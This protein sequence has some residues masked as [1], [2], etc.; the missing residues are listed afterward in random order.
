[1][2]RVA[3]VAACIALLAL[4]LT[5]C[6]DGDGSGL[7]FKD[8][9]GSIDVEEG[10]KFSLEFSVNA[11]VG[12][13]W[14]PVVSPPGQAE[15]LKLEDTVVDYPDEEREGDSG[16]K[17]FV[18]RAERSGKQTLVFRRLFRG[19]EDQRRTVTVSVR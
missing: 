15:I 8:P 6:N 1:V 4:A 17:R 19:D 3:A 13:D 9:K 7:V 18:Y 11:G 5:S 10:M 12:Y 16:K 2:L 14:E